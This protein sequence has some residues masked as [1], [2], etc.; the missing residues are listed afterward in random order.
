MVRDARKSASASRRAGAGRQLMAPPVRD[1]APSDP[2]ELVSIPFKEVVDRKGH[3]RVAPFT[4]WGECTGV[5]D[6]P[7]A[8][9]RMDMCVPP[10]PVPDS[11]GLTRKQC[12]AV[13]ETTTT[14]T[15]DCP[16]DEWRP[17]ASRL[18]E[19]NGP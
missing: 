16:K 7:G 18:N 3:A 4:K 10:D 5:H 14:L 15:M 9:R 17:T 2:G 12:V 11:P 1:Q 13:R 6:Y 19:E 8:R